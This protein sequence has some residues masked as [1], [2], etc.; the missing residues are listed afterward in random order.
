MNVSYLRV[1]L[2][3]LWLLG[4]LDIRYWEVKFFLRMLL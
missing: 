3:S 2:P 4:V 1:K